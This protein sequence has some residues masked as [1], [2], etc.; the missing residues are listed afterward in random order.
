MSLLMIYDML[1]LCLPSKDAIIEFIAGTQY[2]F[3]EEKG[4]GR[5]KESL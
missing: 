5:G 4:K 3:G 1:S 2:I